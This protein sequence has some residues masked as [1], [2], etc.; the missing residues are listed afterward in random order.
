MR[1]VA[2]KL[3]P[4]PTASDRRE[5]ELGLLHSM[6]EEAGCTEAGIRRIPRI[7]YDARRSPPSPPSKVLVERYGS[8]LRAC[9]AAAGLRAPKGEQAGRRP[10]SIRTLGNRRPPAYTRDEV[11][12]AVRRCAVAVD[13][14]PSSNVYYRWAAYWHRR[15]REEGAAP[16]RLPAQRSVERH[17]N[18][19]SEVR[20]VVEAAL[21]E[22]GNEANSGSTVREHS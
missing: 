5:E 21:L 11:L 1:A 4:I 12:D 14:I 2:L 19:W 8:W 10:W 6:L 9:Q 22:H 13:R 7:D 18:S 20:A 17:F 15:A 3:S 16:P